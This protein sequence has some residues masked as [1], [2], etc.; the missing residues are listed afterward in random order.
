MLSYEWS[1]VTDQD[2]TRRHENIHTIIIAFR[3]EMISCR[4]CCTLENAAY[5][6][7][8]LSHDETIDATDG[9]SRT[10]GPGW[11]TSAPGIADSAHSDMLGSIKIQTN[12]L[13]G[14]PPQG[15]KY[16]RLGHKVVTAESSIDPENKSH[17]STP[18]PSQ[19]SLLYRD[20]VAILIVREVFRVLV[21]F[22]FALK[23]SISAKKGHQW[24][25]AYDTLCSNSSGYITPALDPQAHVRS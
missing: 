19:L 8:Y 24:M 5:W 11:A 10:P 14:F 22:P 25:S 21:N 20:V 4:G 13:V 17:S 1:R 9:R 23:H 7:T 3:S 2:R 15:L 12:D 16:S 6:L 18:S